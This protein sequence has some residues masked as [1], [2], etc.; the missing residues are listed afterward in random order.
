MSGGR[1]Y[2]PSQ[3]SVEAAIR[4]LGLDDGM[5]CGVQR[6]LAPLGEWH[7]LVGCVMLN[8]TDRRQAR[9]ALAEIL[10]LAPD[11]ESFVERCV[12]D[13]GLLDAIRP[14]GLVGVRFARLVLMTVDYLRG[15]PLR[16]VFGIGRY[17][18]DSHDIFIMGKRPDPALVSDHELRKY[19]EAQP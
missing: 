7:L 9:R 14:C 17:A 10:R 1:R 6:A 15:V 5:P 16:D 19:L 8:K 3:S 18:L 13:D 4:E 2:F 12:A 11:P